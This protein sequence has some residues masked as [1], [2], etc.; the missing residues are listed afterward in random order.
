LSVLQTRL[1]A[2]GLALLGLVAIAATHGDYGISWDEPVQSR[3]G[4][5]VLQYFASG[6]EDRSVNEFH[7][8]RYYGPLFELTSALLYVGR[9]DAKYEIRH[10]ATALAGL[11]TLLGLVPIAR[12]LPGRLAVVFACLALVTMPRFYGHAFLNSK[13]IPFACAFVAAMGAQ[14]ALALDPR[15]RRRVVLAGLALGAA[16]A[17]RPGGLPLLLLL[18]GALVGYGAWSRRVSDASGLGRIAWSSLAV[19]AIAWAGMVAFWPWAHEAPLLHPVEAIR[20]ALSFPDTFP[21]LFD[22]RIVMSDALPRSYLPRYLAITTP[23][24]HLA[25]AGVGLV[26]SVRLLLREPRAPAA[27]VAFALLLWLCVPLLAIS[28]SGAN[29]YDGIRHVLFTLPA[30][31]LFAGWGAASI[32]DSL[33]QSRR[34]SLMAGALALLLAVHGIHL[35]RLH[36]Y[37]MTYFNAWVGGVEGATGR[38]DTDYWLTSYREA[39]EWVNARAAERSDGPLR[40]LVAVDEH[41]YACAASFV[42]PGVEMEALQT[43][44]TGSMLPDG[45]D[46][47]IATTRFG[48]HGQFDHS[49]VVHHIGRDGGIFAVIRGR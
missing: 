9:P 8:M 37:Q 35:V 43:S 25:L 49:P 31:A 15:S 36:P 44:H 48:M 47:Y 23:T 34:R 32:G 22:G 2:L 39:M 40:V 5:G 20:A 26:A 28:A 21:V 12:R 16:L 41:A 13:D 6:G 11:L 42:G 45:Y 30:I 3:F 4:E 18:H 1:F 7:H 29:V 46:Y 33:R 24:L 14:I 17:I 27:L 38:Y 10:F 19:W